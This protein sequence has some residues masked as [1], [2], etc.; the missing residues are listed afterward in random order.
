MNEQ[1][2]IEINEFNKL[3]IENKINILRNEMITKKIKLKEVYNA[4]LF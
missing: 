1:L 3:T 2:N 4:F